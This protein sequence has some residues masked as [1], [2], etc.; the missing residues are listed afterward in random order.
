MLQLHIIST[1]L[2]WSFLLQTS[3]NIYLCSSPPPLLQGWNFKCL[4]IYSLPYSVH[5]VYTH[6]IL[7]RVYLI[8]KIKGIKNRFQHFSHSLPPCSYLSSMIRIWV[9]TRLRIE[10]WD[11][12]HHLSDY[13]LG[14]HRFENWDLKLGAPPIWLVSG[15]AHVWELRFEIVC[16]SYLTRI[17]AFT[18]LRI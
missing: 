16:T 15:P 6:L 9:C 10:I 13:D 2:S 12:L 11:C 18:F 1:D 14:L 7:D 17:W 3:A 5:F 4:P 8:Q